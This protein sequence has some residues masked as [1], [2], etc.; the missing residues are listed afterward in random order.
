MSGQYPFHEMKM[1]SGTKMGLS[2]SEKRE[3]VNE[4]RRESEMAETFSP[5]FSSG[6]TIAS[7]NNRRIR[8]SGR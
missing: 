7:R 8:E 6:V 3:K 2:A 4:M 1:E 5:S